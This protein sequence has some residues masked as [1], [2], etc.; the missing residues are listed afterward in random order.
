M[1]MNTKVRAPTTPLRTCS[2]CERR[3]CMRRGQARFLAVFGAR[4]ARMDNR[5]TLDRCSRWRQTPSREHRELRRHQLRDSDGDA[6]SRDERDSRSPFRGDA[7][8]S[9]CN[10]AGSDGALD[11]LR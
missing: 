2:T 1:V 4:T 10:S 6:D 9:M 11:R 7:R 3:H 5:E 8:N